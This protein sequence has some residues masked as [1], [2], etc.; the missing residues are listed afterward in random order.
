M[1]KSWT[2]EERLAALALLVAVLSF[3]V[4]E[5]RELLKQRDV[6]NGDTNTAASKAVE[7]PALVLATSTY[8]SP[9]VGLPQPAPSTR[10]MNADANQTSASRKAAA[11]ALPAPDAASATA[12]VSDHVTALGSAD[13]TK[14][15]GPTARSAVGP[16]LVE[17][18]AEEDAQPG[19]VHGHVAVCRFGIA[20][21]Q[22]QG[23]MYSMDRS[24]ICV[25][26]ETKVLRLQLDKSV[27]NEPPVFYQGKRYALGQ[28]H[29]GDEIA[30]EIVHGADMAEPV[31]ATIQLVKRGKL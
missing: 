7:V 12:T 3:L 21:D 4:P 5:I 18:L 8:D 27:L 1:K 9:S 30:A 14:H 26:T 10:G 24:P 15:L 16:D 11:Q 28:L 22:R 6:K 19:I 13:G 17:H 25:R 20:P 23:S 29:V 2:R 31:L